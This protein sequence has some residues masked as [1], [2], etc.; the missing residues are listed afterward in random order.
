MLPQWINMLG[1][2]QWLLLAAIPPAIVAL[3]F[4]KLKR[5]PLEVPSTYLWHKSIEDLHVNSL[6][7]RLRRNLLLWLQLLLL[8]L[9]ILSLLNPGWEGARF[10]GS[11]F[12]FV[13]DHSASMNARD[14]VS[15]DGT[16]AA[17]TR[18]DEAKRRVEVM[19]DAMHTGDAAMIVSFA[20]SAQ[21]VQEFTTNTHRLKRRLRG[22]EPTSRRTSL[23]GALQLAAGLANPGRTGDPED[24][25]DAAAADA[26]PAELFVLS[27]FKFPD[28]QDFS[29]GNL[30]PKFEMI[31]DAA[32]ENLAIVNFNTRRHEQ[33]PD[34]LQA[35]ARLENHAPGDVT[36][37]L[38]LYLDD[39]PRP[40]D[41]RRETIPGRGEATDDVPVNFRQVVFTLPDVER[42]VL[43]LEHDLKDALAVDN[44]AWAVINAPR[45][46][47]VLMV[48][49][50][51][52]AFE[53]AFS[54]PKSQE[55]A[56]VDFAK[57]DA[58]KT[59]QY[60]ERAN[61]GY[62]DL[63]IFDRCQPPEM[64]QANTLFIAG[65]PPTDRWTQ[66]EKLDAPQIVD[67]DRTHPL[68]QLLE[69]G[70][71]YV[72]ESWEVKPPAGG[73]ELIE[74]HN[75]VIAAIGPR[76]G[77]EDAVL[78]FAFEATDEGGQS[79]YNTNWPLRPSFP[80]FIQ[81]VIGYL[82]GRQRLL[83]TGSL[84]PG[85]PYE[86]YRALGPDQL[87]VTGPDGSV[88]TVRRNQQNR[89][90]FSGTDRVGS[91]QV[92]ENRSA[93][94]R[95]VVNLFD[96]LESDI[97]PVS[98]KAAVRIGNVDVD[99][100]SKPDWQTARFQIWKLLVLAGLVVLV[101]EWYIYNRRVY[102]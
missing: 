28:V 27:D 6:W 58:L 53:K 18:L 85:Y 36:V 17:G 3:Y 34:R 45:R 16:E 10:T 31:G 92:N 43:R 11:R 69:M 8:A 22:I 75:G 56:E 19:I 40:I 49:L 78:G 23:A 68:L 9:I 88:R 30:D 55:L 29:L 71:V 46:S 65:V 99:V 48:S 93:P 84:P 5:Q 67:T 90:T 81:D 41:S 83:S 25:Q 77:F 54:T 59:K 95:F 91:Y 38:D 101:F 80:V 72:A 37:T 62:Y 66:G 76:D 73:A 39:G 2:W 1:P 86:I 96:S 21:V 26:R 32:A 20:D 7:Q 44:R 100:H 13:V 74:A 102:L 42:G 35:F 50:G 14:V 94:E 98:G 33:R 4:L 79:F 70:D 97:R 47:R 51:N 89:Y 15:G 82:G 57:P 63:M 52:A 61:S 24:Q 60:A 87:S 12:V 64:P